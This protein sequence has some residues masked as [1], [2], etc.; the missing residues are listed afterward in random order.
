MQSSG[1]QPGSETQI[2]V[3]HVDDDPSI[4]ELTGTFLERKDDRISV[5]TATSATEG[6]E[7][8]DNPDRLRPPDCIV[9]DYDMPGMDGIDF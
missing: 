8:V 5:E 2:Q 3:L 7:T 1:M 9:S 6:L 4:T